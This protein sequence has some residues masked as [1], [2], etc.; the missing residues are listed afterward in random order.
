[1]SWLINMFIIFVITWVA[2]TS[3]E[4][5][6][7]ITEQSKRKKLSLSFGA[8]YIILGLI[9]TFVSIKVH[10]SAWSTIGALMI[11]FGIAIPLILRKQQ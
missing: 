11:G 1:M 6:K 7:T 10:Q 5:L 9:I 8:S 4:K 2:I 3:M